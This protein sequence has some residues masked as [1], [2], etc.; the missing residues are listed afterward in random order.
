MELTYVTT[1]AFFDAG[2]P[3]GHQPDTRP[4]PGQIS[5]VDDD[6]DPK[7][8]LSELPPCIHVIFQIRLRQS[9]LKTSGMNLSKSILRS[10]L[11]S[12]S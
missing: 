11:I 1:V 7:E 2:K 5:N 4:A 6:D 3:A 12:K 10:T 8:S 9:L